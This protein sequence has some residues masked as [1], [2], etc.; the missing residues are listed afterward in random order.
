M[1]LTLRHDERP[2]PLP[3]HSPSTPS[4]L[5]GI[6][7]AI[8]TTQL[9]CTLLLALTSTLAVG[10]EGP[11][12]G[13]PA[14]RLDE[15]EVRELL[16]GDRDAALRVYT[17]V[18][19]DERVPPEIRARA[20][21]R[22]A[23]VERARQNLGRF[24]EAV[25]Q[26]AALAEPGSAISRSAGKL[27]ENWKAVARG[28]NDRTDWLARL[29]ASPRIRSHLLELVTDLASGEDAVRKDASRWLL[30]YGWVALP[31]VRTA[32]AN[33][34]GEFRIELSELL[35]QLGDWR[36]LPELAADGR[37]VFFWRQ[38]QRLN[39]REAVPGDR[40]NLRRF[41]TDSPIDPPTESGRARIALLEASVGMTSNLRHL[42]RDFDRKLVR[43]DW[44]RT[45]SLALDPVEVRTRLEDPE[46]RA[47]TRSLPPL[48]VWPLI[49]NNE[50]GS[51]DQFVERAARDWP[52]L[53]SWALSR[54]NQF[55]TL[56]TLIERGR[57][58]PQRV[59][60]QPNRTYDP[61]AIL[62]HAALP[63]SARQAEV[64]FED[65]MVLTEHY[66]THPE[67]EA[68][69]LQIL[70]YYRDRIVLGAKRGRRNRPNHWTTHSDFWRGRNTRE[71]ANRIHAIAPAQS[72]VQAWRTLIEECP[73]EF[74]VG[75]A[76]LISP[77]LIF[78]PELL[79]DMEGWVDERLIRSIA[80]AVFDLLNRDPGQRGFI[81]EYLAA[82]ASLISRHSAEPSPYSSRRS[83]R[84]HPTAIRLIAMF[85]PREIWHE[86][87]ESPS[88][89]GVVSVA[90]AS[91]FIAPEFQ[92]ELFLRARRQGDHVA[93][94]T[95]IPRQRESLWS[96]LRRTWRLHQ[97]GSPLI[98]D[99]TTLAWAQ[100]LAETVRGD[101]TSA[102]LRFLAFSAYPEASLHHLVELVADPTLAVRW[103]TPQ[104]QEMLLSYL[105][106]Q[107]ES[108][109][110]AVIQALGVD[111]NATVPM[112][113]FRELA[114]GHSPSKRSTRRQLPPRVSGSVDDV[115]GEWKQHFDPQAVRTL[116][117]SLLL[118]DLIV[119]PGV[120]ASVQE[121]L[122]L[123]QRWQRIARG[124]SP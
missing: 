104:A 22:I 3:P 30:G 60:I 62:C 36:T 19:Q 87:L 113:L 53:T 34:T 103:N 73:F 7:T 18:A 8:L 75:Q 98:A 35:F 93:A 24:R 84:S 111:V 26:A 41:L 78:T 63:A 42:P 21:L 38:A 4:A 58:D 27:I 108:D 110:Q 91:R 81:E 13:D 20:W 109:R 44:L 118:S 25:E 105:R 31:T 115:V 64:G 86:L 121:Q 37:D 76:I 114:E 71:N 106:H 29:T 70:R 92:L 99:T 15:A 116:G 66:R 96:N 6:L 59:Q 88:G 23:T 12:P 45:A 56:L 120:R 82:L 90:I 46:F 11:I 74:R 2:N 85:G 5:A 39:W 47:D 50:D 43:Y 122:Q 33:A 97:N 1:A 17:G 112:K 101:E 83:A 65:L 107:S 77:D 52:G 14:K 72:R 51:V 117:K 49:R 9:R 68:R 79:L 28:A 40:K 55:R 32:H 95:L 94:A 124:E 69:Y 123:V 61:Y 48:L 119:D 100:A 10:A 57:I 102:E 80:P 16:D 89:R 54:T 67:F